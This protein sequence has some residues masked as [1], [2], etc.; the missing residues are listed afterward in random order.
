MEAVTKKV[1]KLQLATAQTRIDELERRAAGA[2]DRAKKERERKQKQKAA[3]KAAA[4]QEQQSEQRR[5]AARDPTTETT[6]EN[7]Q[8]IAH[9]A[10]QHLQHAADGGCGSRK[11]GG[12]PGVPP[13]GRCRRAAGL[14]AGALDTN[15]DPAGGERW[16][17]RRSRR[18]R[19]RNSASGSDGGAYGDG[20]GGAWCR[21][22]YYRG[23]RAAGD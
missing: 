6:T 2:S 11:C 3:K 12:A 19:R 22:H 20:C 5:T 16:R 21:P 1:V 17:F 14:W 23:E 4:A 13:H 10:R 18:G 7:A 9:A 8:Q 15:G